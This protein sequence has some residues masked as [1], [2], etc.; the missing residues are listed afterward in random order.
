MAALTGSR[1]VAHDLRSAILR[2]D[3]SP[4]DR[5]PMQSDLSRQYGVALLT[6]RRAIHTLAEEGLVRTRRGFGTEVR[7]RSPMRLPL[8]RYLSSTATAGPW[9]MACAGQRLDGVTEVTEVMPRT[10][11]RTIAGY[12]NLSEG[13]GVVRR[14]NRMRAGAPGAPQRVM[15]LQET[16]LPM[17]VAAGTPLAEPGKVEGGIYRALTAEGHTLAEARE[18]VTGRM[19][20]RAEAKDLGLGSG[21]PVLDIRRTTMDAEGQPVVHTH[22]VV[23]ADSVNLVYRQAL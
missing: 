11:D 13:A 23:S 3:Y 21:S 1:L 10:A 22:L 2:G 9:E 20:S 14:V 8:E 18:T 5:L 19:P 6:V 12:L 4:G 16:W 17:A 15:Q 7:D